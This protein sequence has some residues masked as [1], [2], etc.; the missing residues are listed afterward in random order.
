MVLA[1]QFAPS[2]FVHLEIHYIY[3]WPCYTLHWDQTR[4]HHSSI[5]EWLLVEF[6]WCQKGYSHFAGK[7]DC[8][9]NHHVSIRVLCLLCSCYDMLVRII[10]VL[11]SYFFLIP[12]CIIF[13]FWNINHE[14]WYHFAFPSCDICLRILSH[15]YFFCFLPSI[16]S[17][18][19]FT[20][21]MTLLEYLCAELGLIYLLILRLPKPWSTCC[22]SLARLITY[23]GIPC[24]P[25]ISDFDTMYASLLLRR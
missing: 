18:S 20:C 9:K 10:S 24:A 12:K 5:L 17:S 25:Y 11:L 7:V 15:L 1:L 4:F 21:L 14:I 6:H 22:F 23:I 13:T 19:L 16:F 2:T 8:F 3:R